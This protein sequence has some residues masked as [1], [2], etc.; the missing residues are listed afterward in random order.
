MEKTKKYL[1]GITVIVLMFLSLVAGW[2]IG[3]NEHISIMKEAKA[4]EIT[5]TETPAM[6]A[7][8]PTNYEKV[9]C[10]GHSYIIF[11]KNNNDI[12]VVKLD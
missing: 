1:I 8:Y 6:A 5:S 12:E 7:S 10:Y 3:F 4:A 9:Y 2:M 11:W